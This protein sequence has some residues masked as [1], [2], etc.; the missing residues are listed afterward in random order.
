M[1]RPIMRVILYIHFCN[2]SYLQIAHFCRAADIRVCN[3]VRTLRHLCEREFCNTTDSLSLCLCNRRW[4][5]VIAN[6]LQETTV[7]VQYAAI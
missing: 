2:N 3:I 1:D 6:T 5:S 4:N 7:S